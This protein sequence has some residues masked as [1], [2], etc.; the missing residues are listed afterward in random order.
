MQIHS[1]PRPQIHAVASSQPATAKATVALAVTKAANP[2]GCGGGD[3][4]QRPSPPA[5]AEALAALAVA[6]EATPISRGGGDSRTC[7]DRRPRH[8]RRGS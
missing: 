1:P 2:A 7:G 5:A 6:E 3:S 8:R 4:R